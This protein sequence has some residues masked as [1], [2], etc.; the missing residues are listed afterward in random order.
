MATRAPLISVPKNLYKHF[1]VLTVTITACVAIFADGENK[2]VVAKQIEQ[3]QAAVAKRG[4]FTG[5][6]T[7]QTIGGLRDNR[8]YVVR[9][10]DDLGAP[11]PVAPEE[12]MLAVGEVNEGDLAGAAPRRAQR[13]ASRKLPAVLPPRMPKNPGLTTR[14]AT[15]AATPPAV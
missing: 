10:N 1:A 7:Q 4:R 2:Q 5:G 3:H 14:G 9:G 15:A 8:G 6:G 11:P 12:P 13:A